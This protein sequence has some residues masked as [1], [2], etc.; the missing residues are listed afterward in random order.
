MLYK[1]LR[2][3][4]DTLPPFA[5]NELYDEIAALL[6]KMDAYYFNTVML[7]LDG[8]MKAGDLESAI[9]AYE[10][11]TGIYTRLGP[12]EQANLA[13]VVSALG[14]RIGAGVTA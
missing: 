2:L 6:A 10:K 5:K 14:R 8:H 1:E 13:T 3:T 12:K 9:L 11:L 4:Y 7:E